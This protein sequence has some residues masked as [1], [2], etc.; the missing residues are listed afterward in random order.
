MEQYLRCYTNY[1]QDDWSALLPTAEFV[2]NNS[3]HESIGMSPFMAVTGQD[4]ECEMLMSEEATRITNPPAV[5]TL[6][7]HF[8]SVYQLLDHHLRLAQS[9]YKSTADAHRHQEPEYRINE[10]VLI[11]T[12]NIRTDRPSK[13]LDYTWIGPFR[14]TRKI[15]RVAYEVELPPTSRTHNVFHVKLIKK[16][17]PSNEKDKHVIIPPPIRVDGEQHGYEIEEILDVRKKNNGF[18]Y[19]IKWVGYGTEDN[20]WETRTSIN[21]NELLRDWHSRR[22]DKPTPFKS[23]QGGAWSNLTNGS[24]VTT[25]ASALAEASSNT[26]GAPLVRMPRSAVETEG[27]RRG[28]FRQLGCSV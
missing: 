14:I 18:Q 8:R 16:Y 6:R 20:S 7:D 24:F 23:L 1:N 28:S 21:D 12:R 5:G 11:S 25:V 17:I 4:A 26:R 9:R 3:H 15:N 2:Y 27:G 13:K 19:L 22:P 10:L